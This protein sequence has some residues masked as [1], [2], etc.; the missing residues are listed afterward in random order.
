MEFNR[1]YCKKLVITL[2]TLVFSCTMQAQ[3]KFEM[4]KYGD[5]NQW[6]TRHVKESLVIGGDTKTLYEVAPT[7]VWD[8]NNAYTPQGGSI[9]GC[10][11]IMAKVAGVVKTNVS[12]YK[13]ER[14]GHGYCA[15]LMTH[16]EQVKVLGLV[17]IKVLAP[18]AMFLGQIFEPITGTKDPMRKMNWGIP[19]KKHPK[20]ICFDYKVKLMG[21]TTRE[22]RTGFSPVKTINGMDMCDFVLYLQKRW[23]DADGN[24]FAKRVGT[25][26]HRFDKS[27]SGWVN[28]KQFAIH[29]GD[30][31]KEPFFKEYM[32]LTTGELV[33]CA[34][35]SKGKIVPVNEI[36]WA[37]PD[38]MPTHLCLQF[39]SSF[40][41]AYV[42]SVGNTLWVDN[43]R[44]V[45]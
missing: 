20:A 32:G 7:A 33:R 3:D 10:S 23:E 29:Y 17:N 43:I 38:E 12:V 41:E 24:I 31:T 5:M 27:T 2:L 28:D 40:G 22:K 37:E 25:I 18:G 26:V 21:G 19:F 44:M 14:P 4:L 30:I 36:G 1:G 42:G 11:N 8:N 34:R 35:N 39:D 6:I 45:Y 15:K 13:E 9:W 16:H